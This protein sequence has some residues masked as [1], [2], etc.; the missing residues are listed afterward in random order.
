MGWDYK[1]DVLRHKYAELPEENKS[2]SKKK[3]SPPKKAKHKHVY[4]NCMVVS[5]EEPLRCVKTHQPDYHEESWAYMT[6]YCTVCSK[7]NSCIDDGFYLQALEKHDDVPKRRYSWWYQAS[8][9]MSNYGQNRYYK[10]R[11]FKALFDHYSQEGKVFYQD[12][13][14]YGDTKF[15]NI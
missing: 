8:F 13:F 14:R 9:S 11:Q 4:E 10:D 1:E 5:K 12:G 3:K 15:I 2:K 6:G 7:V